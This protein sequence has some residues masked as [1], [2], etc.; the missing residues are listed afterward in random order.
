[1]LLMV[2]DQER[3]AELAK[4]VESRGLEVA[5]ARGADFTTALAR[6]APDAVVLDLAAPTLHGVAALLELRE[7]RIHTGLPVLVVTRPGLN[8][9]EQEIIR[10]LATVAADPR[11]V[12]RQ[13]ATL[14][15]ASF[16]AA[17]AGADGS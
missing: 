6:E 2:S 1:M 15:D 11:N 7:D 5:E 9:K 4:V 17:G 8:A 10:E 13:L 14:L 3:H 12:G 16:P